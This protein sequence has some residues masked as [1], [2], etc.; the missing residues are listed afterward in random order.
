[1]LLAALRIRLSHSRALGPGTRDVEPGQPRS[2]I[3]LENIV[4]SRPPGTRG[5]GGSSGVALDLSTFLRSTG[6]MSP[7]R[8]G[9]TRISKSSQNR[10]A[11]NPNLSYPARE[12]PENP[13][14]SNHS[15][16]SHHSSFK[17]FKSFK[18]HS[19]SQ[20]PNPRFQVPG[21]R[22]QV[23]VPI[24][25]ATSSRFQSPCPEFQSPF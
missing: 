21:S 19:K 13:N 7:N 2:T 18:S 16:H 24:F 14:H 9:F 4:G 15:Y 11:K 22:S 17:S 6:K 1:M 8:Y 23:P 25:Q 5:L 3:I 12:S 20:A 10:G